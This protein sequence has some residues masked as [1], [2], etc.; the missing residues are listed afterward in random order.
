MVA[1]S[2]LRSGRACPT[3]PNP[4]EKPLAHSSS[5]GREVQVRIRAGRRFEPQKDWWE[6]VLDSWQ[7]KGVGNGKAPDLLLLLL[8]FLFLL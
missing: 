7:R 3:T 2:G 1:Q 6:L 8:L 5:G 4:R